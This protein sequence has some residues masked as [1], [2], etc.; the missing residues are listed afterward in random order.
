MKA[1]FLLEKRYGVPL[2]SEIAKKPEAF[3]REIHDQGPLKQKGILPSISRWLRL[4][5]EIKPTWENLFR[6]LH[7]IGLGPLAWQMVDRLLK[8][9]IGIYIII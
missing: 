5:S 8:A 6:V 7:N 2:L 1:I 4:D 3:Q 9:M